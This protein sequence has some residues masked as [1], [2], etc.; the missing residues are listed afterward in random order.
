MKELCRSLVWGSNNLSDRAVLALED[1]G[2]PAT[3][4]DIQEHLGED[5]SIRSIHVALSRDDR[6][7]NTGPKLWGLSS[8]NLTK[9]VSIA[10]HM[11]EMLEKRDEM[12]VAEL[13]DVLSRTYQAKQATIKAEAD[14]HP[15]VIQDGNIR[16]RRK[17]DPLIKRGRGPIDPGN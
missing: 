14:S 7:V 5:V 15:F 8:W 17:D 4:H 9:Y 16:M 11:R 1:L 10:H 6:L 13:I 3:A 12:P 2:N